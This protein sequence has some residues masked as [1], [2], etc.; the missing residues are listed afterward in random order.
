MILILF[1]PFSRNPPY[2]RYVFQRSFAGI[3]LIPN[4]SITARG[5]D[6]CTSLFSSGL[7]F[8][9][10]YRQHI[11][12]Y[13]LFRKQ[14]RYSASQPSRKASAGQAAKATP[15]HVGLMV[16]IVCVFN[17]HSEV[18]RFHATSLQPYSRQKYV[19]V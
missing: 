2:H 18:G 12:F 10:G 17:V 1:F 14:F 3:T 6:A 5:R 11:F 4:T 8:G 13:A 9:F 16:L 15:G 7:D 19:H